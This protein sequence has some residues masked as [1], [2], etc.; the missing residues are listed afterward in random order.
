MQ[1]YINMYTT[2]T[3]MDIWFLV[4]DGISKEEGQKIFYERKKKKKT[5][6]EKIFNFILSHLI[7]Q[8]CKYDYKNL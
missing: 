1:Y 8:C 3:W 2:Y 5:F 6:D 4:K 7:F